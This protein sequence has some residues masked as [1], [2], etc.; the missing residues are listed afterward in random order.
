[1]KRD[2]EGKKYA[3]QVIKDESNISK[4]DAA[5]SVTFENLLALGKMEAIASGGHADDVSLE[6][7]KFGEVQLPLAPRNN[8]KFRYDPVVTQVTNLLMKHGKLSVAQRVGFQFLCNFCDSILFCSISN[9]DTNIHFYR[10]W[11]SS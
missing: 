4:K 6:G 8:L 7:L 9:L 5:G 3:P 11:G 2:E 1:L 10:T